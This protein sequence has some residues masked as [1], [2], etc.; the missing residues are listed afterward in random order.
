MVIFNFLRGCHIKHNGP[1]LVF[2]T[3]LW[4][5]LLTNVGPQRVRR[6]DGDGDILPNIITTS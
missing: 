6:S 1:D 4:S 2:E 5:A 3:F